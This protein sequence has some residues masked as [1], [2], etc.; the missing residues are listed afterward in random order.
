M[1]TV[2]ELVASSAGIRVQRYADCFLSDYEILK[3]MPSLFVMTGVVAQVIASLLIFV[4]L[5]LIVC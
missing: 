1:V 5:S 2:Q 4:N 3:T